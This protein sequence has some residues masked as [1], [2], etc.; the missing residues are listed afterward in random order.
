[1]PVA[2][3]SGRIGGSKDPKR[4]ERAEL[5][6]H[7]FYNG[8][9]IYNGNGDQTI[10]LENIQN[11]IIETDAFIYT[12]A[13]TLEDYFN[14]AS[15][16]V[17]YQTK[18][19]DLDK[20]PAIIMN[21]DNSWDSFISLIKHLNKLGTIKQKAQEYVDI[22]EDAEQVINILDKKYIAQLHLPAE[23]P[24]I[25]DAGVIYDH[26]V[27]ESNVQKPDYNV[28]V[29]CS[30]S[31][32]KESYLEEGYKL[33]ELLAKNNM[34]CVSGAG[35]TGIMGAVVEG[36][37]QNGGWCGG[38]NVPHII[39]LEGLPEGLT[40][41]W[42]RADIYT[43]MEVMIEKSDAFIIMPGGMGTIQELMAMLVLKHKNNDLMR[44][45]KIVVYNRFDE[46]LG[47]RFW[48]PCIDIIKK[49]NI[50]KDDIIVVDKFEDIMKKIK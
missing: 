3:L 4:K 6:Y 2:R 12:S 9:D 22:I 1:M 11:K 45:K 30:A 41:F 28:C 34:G 38:S 49:Q 7:L 17:G 36:S 44:D 20:K 47:V 18:D 16:F 42:P 15:I 10:H 31:I 23:E 26:G 29:F 40:E 48:Q 14:M 35:K 25:I 50:F 27:T 46:D 5:L 21:S 43:R 32:Q 19:K 37:S 13:P 39:K 33:G 8:W 24:D